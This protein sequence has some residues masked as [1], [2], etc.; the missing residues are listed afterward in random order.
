MLAKTS[1]TIPLPTPFESLARLKQVHLKKMA[2]IDSYKKGIC[3]TLGPLVAS[4]WKS[5]MDSC[6][7]TTLI[8]SSTAWWAPSDNPVSPIFYLWAVQGPMYSSGT[9]HA[10]VGTAAV[11]SVET[12]TET[13]FA[14]MPASS[15]VLDTTTAHLFSL[16]PGGTNSSAL[17]A[18][19][20]SAT[21]HDKH[22]HREKAGEVSSPP[23]DA[24]CTETKQLPLRWVQGTTFPCA[25]HLSVC[26]ST[27]DKSGTNIQQHHFR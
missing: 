11:G 2:E 3:R 14:S 27:S 13:D 5:L 18:D 17:A 10:A 15:P 19:P 22:A 9:I 23:A 21:L 16:A 1:F 4:L 25:Q 20:K 24:S 8:N 26:F 6:P 7:R 12:A